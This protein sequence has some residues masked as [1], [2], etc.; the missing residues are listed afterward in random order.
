MKNRRVKQVFFRVGTTG[1]GEHKERVN[2]DEW[3][4]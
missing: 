4:I 3:W 1:R 2:E